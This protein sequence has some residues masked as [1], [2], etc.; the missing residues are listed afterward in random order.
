MAK[1]RISRIY[2]CQSKVMNEF[3]DRTTKKNWRDGDDRDSHEFWDSQQNE[4]LQHNPSHQVLFVVHVNNF[5][6]GYI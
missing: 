3:I 2:C 1:Y 5:E 4:Y 6:E